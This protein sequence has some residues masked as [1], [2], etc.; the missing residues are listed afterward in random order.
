MA[1][2]LV[3]KA[4]KRLARVLFRPSGMN[5]SSKNLKGIKMAFLRMLAGAIRTCGSPS[6]AAMDFGGFE[7]QE[8][9]QRIPIVR[10]G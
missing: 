7:V 8:G 6:G 2:N 5:K 1:K 9:R 3:N 10:S 4:L